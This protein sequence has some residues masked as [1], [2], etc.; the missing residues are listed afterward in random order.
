MLLAA[1]VLLFSQGRDWTVQDSVAVRYFVTNWFVPPGWRQPPSPA[2]RPIIL[3][4]DGEHFFSLSYRGELK[5]DRVLY[6]LSIFS[7][8]DV[9]TALGQGKKNVD[10]KH[11][12]SLGSAHSDGSDPFATA[13]IAHP[14]WEGSKAVVFVGLEGPGPHRLYRFSL[15][16]GELR[17]LTSGDEDVVGAPGSSFVVSGDSVVFLNSERQP[18]TPL[19]RYPM[20]VV[21]GDDLWQLMEPTK[22]VWKLH[23]VHRGGAPR[24][25]L[26]GTADTFAFGPALSPDGRFAIVVCPTLDAPIPSSWMDYE[27]KPD[28]GYHAVLFDLE[29]GSRRSVLSAPI[30]TVTQAGRGLQQP[31]SSFFTADS[32]HVVLFNTTL[33]LGENLP[34][35]RKT[36][37]VV[38]YDLETGRHHVLTPIVDESGSRAMRAEWITEGRQLAI[39]RES[40]S[41][42]MRD[43]YRYDPG[44]GWTL[45]RAHQ[46]V[47][48]DGA[49]APSQPPGLNIKL[50]QSPNDPPEIVAEAQGRR[51]SLTGKDDA[52]S[53]IWRADARRIEWKED[54]GKKAAGLLMLPREAKPRLPLVI[55]AEVD[56]ESFRPD[57]TVPAAFAAQSLVAAG[58]AVLQLEFFRD[59]PVYS[60]EEGPSRVRRIDA[61]VAELARQNLVDPERVGLIGFSRSGYQTYYVLTHPGRTNVAAAIV[62]DS[63]TASYGEYAISAGFGDMDVGSYE[64][65]YGRGTF[66]QNKQGWLDAPAFNLDRLQAPIMFATTGETTRWAMLETV[67]AFRIAQRPFEYL[68]FPQATHAL[69]RPTE[70]VAA[71]QA[72]VDWMVFWL[73]DRESTIASPERLERWSKIRDE[74]HRHQKGRELDGTA[75]S[76]E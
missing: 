74:W 50:L 7:V 4:P 35:R 21:S 59:L 73:Q 57:G 60:S 67:G 52:L 20:S 24:L 23:S 56:F 62:F 69:Q 76:A 6:E 48:A 36:P 19:D 43:I 66:W 63:I 22:L 26:K 3:S 25:L 65:Q 68:Y 40:A 33:P 64:Q 58:F 41:G 72:A 28:K 47:A 51:V 11:R 38:D 32:K 46:R 49:A 53:G 15:Q 16:K 54:D 8:R 34:E 13:A 5:T 18:W 71:M 2:D 12:I 61:A 17:A 42:P 30:G 31:F 70:Q 1:P 45:V 14:Y 9:R 39:W 37:Y 10:P 55:Q 29:A 44:K 27:L 75:P